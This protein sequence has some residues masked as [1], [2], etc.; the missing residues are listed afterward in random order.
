MK[1]VTMTGKECEQNAMSCRKPQG[2]LK[3]SEATSVHGSS[4]TAHPCAIALPK[5]IFS[6]P[7]KAHQEFVI[8]VLFAL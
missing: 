8:V 7:S 5:V 2:N 1:S 3:L 6:T 4:L